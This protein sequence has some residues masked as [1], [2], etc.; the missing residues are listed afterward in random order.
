MYLYPIYTL[1]LK[2]IQLIKLFLTDDLNNLLEIRIKH[3]EQN[4]K[5][6]KTIQEIKAR[7]I[8]NDLFNIGIDLEDR[9]IKL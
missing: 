4:D 8:L 2:I 9:K 7:T 1:I 5:I 6:L 3:L